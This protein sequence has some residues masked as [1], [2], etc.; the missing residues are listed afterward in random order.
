MSQQITFTLQTSLSLYSL[1]PCD[2]L[3][4]LTGL[5]CEWPRRQPKA[6]WTLPHETT[7]PSA[8]YFSRHLLSVWAGPIGH[9]KDSII[10]LWYL[11]LHYTWTTYFFIM[12]Y[13]FIILS[14][15]TQTIYHIIIYNTITYRIY[16]WYN[17]MM[18]FCLWLLHFLNNFHV[19]PWLFQ[20]FNIYI[21]I[22]WKP[23]KSFKW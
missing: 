20:L 7:T 10:C 3:P 4:P 18:S 8:A 1:K 19:L 22:Y 2:I 23:Q 13:D 16:T 5:N 15:N 17:L 21:Y 9:H 12:T 6:L 14:T 11:N